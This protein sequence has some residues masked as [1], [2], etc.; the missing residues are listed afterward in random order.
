MGNFLSGAHARLIFMS[1]TRR[2]ASPVTSGPGPV[3]TDLVLP[4]KEGRHEHAL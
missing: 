1:G 3:N 4:Q 2:A